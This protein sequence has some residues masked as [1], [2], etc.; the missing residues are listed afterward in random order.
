VRLSISNLT[1]TD[2]PFG[3]YGSAYDSGIGREHTLGINYRF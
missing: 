2:A 1:D 3:Q